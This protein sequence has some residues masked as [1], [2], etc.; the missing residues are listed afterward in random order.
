MCRGKAYIYRLG[1]YTTMLKPSTGGKNMLRECR[2]KA[3]L[4]GRWDTRQTLESICLSSD[5]RK[6]EKNVQPRNQLLNQGNVSRRSPVPQSRGILSIYS[7]GDNRKFWKHYDRMEWSWIS[8][9]WHVWVGLWRCYS[10]CEPRTWNNSFD[11]RRIRHVQ[12]L[13]EV[14]ETGSRRWMGAHLNVRR[15]PTARAKRNHSLASLHCTSSGSMPT[16]SSVCSRNEAD[17]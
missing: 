7:G 11:S 17:V 16:S 3:F 15:D 6:G 2:Y 1:E 13:S 4:E 9:H 12:L 10:G 5:N 14:A 8:H